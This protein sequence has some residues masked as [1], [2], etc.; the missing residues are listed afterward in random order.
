M[1]EQATGSSDLSS[2]WHGRHAGLEDRWR[3]KRRQRAVCK[4]PP[5]FPVGEYERVKVAFESID[6]IELEDYLTPSESYFERKIGQ[7]QSIFKAE[8]LSEVTNKCQQEL[9]EK[10]N[11]PAPGL[12]F[13]ARGIGT[14][15]LKKSDFCVSL[16]ETPEAFKHR[17]GLLGTC[18]VFLKLM[19]PSNP[20]L[21][22][23]SMDIF[24]RY[25][26]Y[27]CGPQVWGFCT[28]NE[29]GMPI[30][31][32]HIGHVLSYD[33]AIRQF[34]C[35]SMNGGADFQSALEAALA[36]ANI[37]LRHFTT[38]YSVEASTDRCKAL[39]A[40]GLLEQY[41]IAPRGAKR[42][43]PRDSSADDAGISKNQKKKLK[44]AEAQA[45]AAAEASAQ[46]KAAARAQRSGKGGQKGQKGAGK[47]G[48]ADGK[49][50]LAA[51]PAGILSRHPTSNKP[52]CYSWNQGKA[53]GAN[54]CKCCH[55]CWKFGSSE[56]RGC[57]NAC[58][59]GVA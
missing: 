25:A 28:K 2:S 55:A 41:G 17:L 1:P 58:A 48:K 34:V 51:L 10:S 49:N 45:K 59:A 46:A 24:R 27:M 19:Y 30:S 9:H 36:N 57:D 53:C 16:P 47:G 43:A 54:P 40:Q 7:V 33:L 42:P 38:A 14:F 23:V 4:L 18:H 39:T 21:T 52:L 35:K 37:R 29:F 15:K 56:H 5:Q 13:D 20:K 6:K 12:D 11:L 32:P 8:P 3:S 22:T 26:D 50:A 44:K 31:S